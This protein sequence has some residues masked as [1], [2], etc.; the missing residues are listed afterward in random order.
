[1]K[2]GTPEIDPSRREFVK[3]TAAAGAAA[4]ALG[5]AGEH[6]TAA[7]PKWDR[8]ADV[9]IVGPAPPGCPRRFVLAIAARLSFSSIRITTSVVTR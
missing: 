2:H 5:V 7:P 9:V 3:K 6:A 1:M 8:S 4:A